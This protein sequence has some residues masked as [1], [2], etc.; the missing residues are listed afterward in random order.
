IYVAAANGG[1]W[2]TTNHGN[3]WTPLTD[4]QAT[5]HMGA[6]AIAP[7]NPNVIYAGTGEANGGMNSVNPYLPSTVYAGKGVLKS[8]DGGSNWVLLGASTFGRRSISKI[9]VD[10]A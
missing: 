9:I 7:S 5:L 10:P 1:V 8:T 4:N 2:K 3:T 6:I